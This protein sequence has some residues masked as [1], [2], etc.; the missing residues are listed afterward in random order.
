MKCGGARAPGMRG[1]ARPDENE[2]DFFPVRGGADERDLVWPLLCLASLR[3][4]NGF[5]E[6]TC[7]AMWTRI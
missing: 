5:T 2:L 1:S 3:P 4:I 6:G 7:A